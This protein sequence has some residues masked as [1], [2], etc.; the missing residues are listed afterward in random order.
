MTAKASALRGNYP[1]TSELLLA[2]DQQRPRSQQREIG[3]SEIGGCRRRAGYR[4]AGT[5]PTNPGSS[6]QAVL[7][8]AIHDAIAA[9]LAQTAGPNDLA[10]HRVTFAGVVGTLDRYEADTFTV[11]DVKTTTSRWLEHIR[12]YG[13]DRDHL[14][15]TTGYG[16]ALIAEGRKVRWLRIDY[17]A[18]DTGEEHSVVRPFDV[19]VLRDA[20]DWIDAV[21]QTPLEM[22]NRDYEPDSSFCGHCPFFDPTGTAGCWEGAVPDRDLRSV[23]FVEDPDARGWAER[24]WKAQ[25]DKRDAAKREKEAKGALD[26]LRPNDEGSQL[27]DVGFDVPLKFRVSK[28]QKR[29]DND[30]VRAEYRAAGATPPIKETKQSIVIQ[31]AGSEDDDA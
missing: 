18:R 20:L 29:L 16:A 30:R 1:S 14:W 7:G 4:L 17:I 15:Q 22:L 24:L 26:A 21:R 25:A 9:I 31:F 28:P 3:W 6:V 23:L 11:V 10:E 8:T 12:I 5:E 13:P 27:V 19:N 2:W